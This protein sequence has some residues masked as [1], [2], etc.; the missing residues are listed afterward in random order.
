VVR[1]DHLAHHRLAD[2]TA[3]L[4]DVEARRLVRRSGGEASR[5]AAGA[6]GDGDVEVAGLLDPAVLGD[7]EDSTER[8][9]DGVQDRIG[10]VRCSG[11]PQRIEEGG[12]KAPRSLWIPQSQ[13]KPSR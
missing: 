9:L 8:G 12:R 6:I 4:V 11:A 5:Y 13:R 10:R 3:S 2:V 1:L 7:I